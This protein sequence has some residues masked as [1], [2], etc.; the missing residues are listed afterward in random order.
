MNK[1]LT[2]SSRFIRI[3]TTKITSIDFELFS[4]LYCFDHF[5]Y[6]DRFEMIFYKRYCNDRVLRN[7]NTLLE[8]DSC[9]CQIYHHDFF[10]RVL[11][12]SFCRDRR[13]DHYSVSHFVMRQCRFDRFDCRTE[14]D[15]IWYFR[16]NTIS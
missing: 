3:C 16:S 9:R 2:I 8:I 4:S 13:F 15:V 6:F 12:N 11:Y 10:C 14:I 1:Y 7:F 5:D